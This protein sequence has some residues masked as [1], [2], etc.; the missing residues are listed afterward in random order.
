MTAGNTL[1]SEVRL[2]VKKF[3]LRLRHKHLAGVKYE[4][5][6][7]NVAIGL[8]LAGLAA[9]LLARSRRLGRR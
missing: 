3:K 4:D 8:S 1:L 6:S 9:L 7:V 2:A 5:I